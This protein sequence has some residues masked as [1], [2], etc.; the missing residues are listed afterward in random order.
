MVR[1]YAAEL[2]MTMA[3]ANLI[4]PG[5]TRTAMRAKAMP[6]EDPESLPPPDALEDAFLRLAGADFTENGALY[7]APSK[8]IVR[9]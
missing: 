2:A 5:A 1:V 9:F 3:R 8:K 6:G 4:D 7:D